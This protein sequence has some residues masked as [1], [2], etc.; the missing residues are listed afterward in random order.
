MDNKINGESADHSHTNKES[1]PWWQ[2]S[3]NEKIVL[4]RY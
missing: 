1:N 2:I 3:F 4:T